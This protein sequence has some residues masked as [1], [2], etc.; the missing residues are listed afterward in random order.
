MKDSDFSEVHEAQVAAFAEALPMVSKSNI[1]PFGDAKTP[2]INDP[3]LLL[4][5]AELDIDELKKG[6]G[7]KIW[8]RAQF[9][10]HCMLPRSVPL[11][12][13]ECINF[14]A[15]VLKIVHRNTW[16]L[17]HV[18]KPEQLNAVP[19]RY[20][21]D[22]KGFESWIVSWWQTVAIGDN[23]QLPA[24]APEHVMLSEAPHV[25]ADHKAS[26][27]KLEDGHKPISTN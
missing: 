12:S 24:P 26:Y 16:Q 8:V 27:E 11:V 25:G 9:Q 5:V 21:N 20:S 4:E 6:S 14:A 15:V 13:I 3:T 19:G 22:P 10:A 2:Q 18:G 17:A 1:L 7:G 23:W